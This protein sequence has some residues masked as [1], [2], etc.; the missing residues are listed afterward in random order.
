[1]KKTKVNANEAQNNKEEKKEKKEL[2]GTQEKVIEEE[3][4]IIKI[5][6]LLIK[7]IDKKINY[8]LLF[9]LIL[10][11]TIGI[12]LNQSEAKKYLNN[13]SNGNDLNLNEANNG[14]GQTV[15][16]IH[17]NL[18]ENE[19]RNLNKD[20]SGDSKIKDAETSSQSTL[21]DESPSK[22]TTT[23]SSIKNSKESDLKSSTTTKTMV[24][25]AETLKSK[26]DL[27]ETKNDSSENNKKTSK[28]KKTDDKSN[29]KNTTP[30]DENNLKKRSKSIDKESSNDSAK[31]FE[32]KDS[33]ND[34]IE[35]KN[36]AKQNKKEKKVEDSLINEKLQRSEDS[37]I[38][39]K[40]DEPIIL[41]GQK[42]I[43]PVSIE[44]DGDNT[45]KVKT[46]NNDEK[47]M[48][49]RPRTENVKVAEPII[50]PEEKE[51]PQSSYSKQKP[52]SPDKDI[53]NF[54]SIKISELKPKKMWIPIPGSKGGH[55]R[56]PAVAIT[57]G[58]E[59]KSSVK[60]WLYEEFFTKEECENLIKV[61]D[62]HVR[63]L[64]SRKPIICF[65]SI[66]TLRKILNELD[67]SEIAQ[68]V[69][70]NDFI[71]GTRCIN[72]SLSENLGK[73]GLKWSFTTAFYL[74]E[75]KFSKVF[76][77]RIEEV[78]N[79]IFSFTMHCTIF[80][81]TKRQHN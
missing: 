46:V 14:G 45:V 58:K 75:S 50:P 41:S 77:R 81:C 66:K 59:H 63:V 29:D 36:N 35:K 12:Y 11:I 40:S 39:G 30:L 3:E 62:D 71:E 73:W 54:R 20:E 28:E 37:V 16:T 48:K 19:E 10:A 7:T 60:M 80:F 52:V 18:G 34:D 8:K 79:F 67:K 33:K 17:E 69:T 44:I 42:T 56:V 38:N 78:S 4:S 74:G 64:S 65:D 5:T 15:Q 21:S 6:C 26:N 70:P 47:K 76:S 9:F 55:R 49:K 1:M 72:Q 2:N 22:S 23:E 43:Q 51:E 31:G 25:S 27:E 57:A 24:S 32:L 53:A 13:N 68:S 61:H